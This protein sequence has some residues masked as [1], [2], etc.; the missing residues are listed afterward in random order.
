M[1]VEMLLT[2]IAALVLANSINR[3]IVNPM[4]NY[5]F[6]VGSK[7]KAG[8]SSLDGSANSAGK[9]AI[10]ECEESI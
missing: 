10:K 4:L 7:H 8:C 9:R 2:I 1:N 5:L 6:G 3:V